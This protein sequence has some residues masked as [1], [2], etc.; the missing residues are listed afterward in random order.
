[1]QE[2]KWLNSHIGAMDDAIKLINQFYWHISVQQIGEEWIVRSGDPIILRSDNKDSVDAFL[3]GIAL[4]Y[5]IIP[6]HMVKEFRE[7]FNLDDF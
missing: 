7:M 2:L 6:E 5:S 3:Y 4:A 1:M